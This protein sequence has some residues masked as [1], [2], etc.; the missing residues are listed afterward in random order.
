M[1]RFC[2]LGWAGLVLSLCGPLSFGAEARRI[3]V[4]TSFLPVYCFTANVAG[5]LA[6]VEN[7]LPANVEPHDYQFSRRD[8]QKLTRA[9]LIMVNGLGLERWLEKAFAISGGRSQKV[10]EI[11]AGLES[12]WIASGVG[13]V[14]N[15]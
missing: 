3:S 7:L 12:E 13:G 8:L 10:V 4:L 14:P 9:D 15:P 11:A 2:G 5:E 1:S 6:Q